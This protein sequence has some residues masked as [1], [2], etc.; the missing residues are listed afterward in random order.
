[1][2]DNTFWTLKDIFS[3]D[4][5]EIPRYQRNYAWTKDEIDTLIEDIEEAVTSSE[6]DNY[7]V[8]TLIVFKRIESKKV[9]FETID[10]QQRLT[11]F[12]LLLCLLKNSKQLNIK[13]TEFLYN[14]FKM[15]LSFKS[16]N[17]S[18]LF[19]NYIYNNYYSKKNASKDYDNSLVQGYELIEKALQTV[20][21]IDKFVSFLCNKIKIL[22]VEV[23]PYTDLNHYFEIMN[24]RGE[25]LD[26]P[27]Y[28]KSV[29]MEVFKDNDYEQKKFNTIWE[30]C[31]EIDRYVQMPF[32]VTIR[33]KLFGRWWNE[34]LPKNYTNI[35]LRA[36]KTATEIEE[37]IDTILRNDDYIIRKK[38][39]TSIED[40]ERF[41]SIISFSNFLLHVLRI[42]INNDKNFTCDKESS[43]DN[44][45]L[46]SQFTK[47]YKN[48][49]SNPDNVKNFAFNLF[50]CRY[51]SDTY[52][53]KRDSLIDDWGL[54]K[55]YK[56]SWTNGYYVKHTFSGRDNVDSS[57]I[58]SKIDDS[59]KQLLMIISMFHVSYPTQT[60][61][62]WYNGVLD[63]LF[64]SWKTDGYI[65]PQK[66]LQFL[67]EFACKIFVSQYIGTENNKDTCSFYNVI[68]N[69]QLNDFSQNFYWKNLNRGTQVEMFVFNYLDYI[70]WKKYK[71]RGDTS[72]LIKA[73]CDKFRFTQRTSVEHFFPQK[74]EDSKRLADNDLNSFGNLSLLSQSENSRMTNRVPG[75]KAQA[76]FNTLDTRKTI[77]SL[78]YHIM[79]KICK[80]NTYEWNENDIR[81][82][83]KEMID[84][85]KDELRRYE[86]TV[87]N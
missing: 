42:Q 78:K 22:R 53:I 75:S 19:L 83:E 8:G 57:D 52:I 81:P 15:N 49:F 26:P 1:M 82:F 80:N 35:D 37:P 30:N 11:T 41:S 17:E 33:S 63:Y 29:L 13:E 85:L 28:V 4:Y 47:K 65:N 14:N 62:N 60:R 9:I 43:L 21:D 69:K 73:E 5:Y 7:Y 46:I 64:K 6:D 32:S 59:T 2:S 77:P 67:E 76:Y 70:L 86:L 39:Q 10:G 16:R 23:P 27:E 36:D 45:E 84:V 56:Q 34:F 68:Y 12:I 38:E 24:T 50:L 66:Y 61:K 48:Y 25:Q 20:K 72:R 18:D 3:Y 87:N 55:L 71:S 44:K 31:S 58:N 79:M 51:L 74:S 40:P 54:N